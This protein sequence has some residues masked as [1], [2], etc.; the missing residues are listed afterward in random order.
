M[1][2]ENLKFYYRYL[3]NRFSK[4]PIIYNNSFNL[5]KILNHFHINKVIDVGAYTGT[6]AQSLRR[7]GYKGKIISFE[8]VK[9]SYDILLENS[10]KDKNWIVY[11]KIALGSKKSK[12]KI[13]ISKKSDSSSILKIKKRHVKLEPSSK[14][15]SQEEVKL[16]K[17]DNILKNFNIKK[18]SCLLK[19]D[20]QGY[21]YEVLQGAKKNLKKFKLIQ[22]ELSLVELYSK[23]K[24][25]EKIINFLKKNKFETWC[26]FPGFRDKKNGQLLQYDIILHKKNNL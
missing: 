22:L 24:K 6:Y 19:I 14:I 15:I 1:L 20:T 26:I 11:E 18:D 3:V 8:P 17:L 10:S 7:F 13:N 25:I 23:Q 16:D 12:V 2:I 9:K 5:Q 21:E 4:Y